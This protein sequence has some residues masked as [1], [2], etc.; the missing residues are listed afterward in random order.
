MKDVYNKEEIKK[1][2]DFEKNFKGWQPIRVLKSESRAP[3][4]SHLKIKL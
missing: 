3:M 4:V 2:K 1:I